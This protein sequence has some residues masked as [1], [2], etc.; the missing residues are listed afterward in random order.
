MFSV[1]RTFRAAIPENWIDWVEGM[2]V[3]AALVLFPD[4]AD[5]LANYD[6]VAAFDS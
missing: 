2:V 4:N 6:F 3:G 5:Y 1:A